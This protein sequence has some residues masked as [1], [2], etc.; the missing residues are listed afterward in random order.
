M[1]TPTSMSQGGSHNSVAHGE[2]FNKLPIIIVGAVVA[3]FAFGLYYAA[4]SRIKPTATFD[5][6]T[7]NLETLN[8][9]QNYESIEFMEGQKDG[10]V[11]AIV[12][13][14][15]APLSGDDTRES[16]LADQLASM[17]EKQR[18]AE[19]QRDSE[20]QSQMVK[21]Q[22]DQAQQA[23][24]GDVDVAAFDQAIA[25]G[26]PEKQPFNYADPS[27][28]PNTSSVTG[29]NN[30]PAN[31]RQQPV[32][33]GSSNR[34]SNPDAAALSS[35]DT[36]GVV[37]GR[38]FVSGYYRNDFTLHESTS[39]PTS[40]YQLMTGTLIPGSMISAANSELPGDL[41]AQVRQD[42]YDSVTGRHLLIPKGSKLFGRY[43]S[44]AALGSERL[45][46]VWDRLILP[47][48]ESLTLGSIQGYDER[49]MSGAKDQVITHFWK[50]LFNA[51]LLSVASN[52][53]EALVDESDKSGSII[54]DITAS[55]GTTSSGA[56]DDYLRHRLRIKPT[57]QIRAGYRFN[58]IV[59]RD[60]TFPEPFEFG[61]TR[62]EIR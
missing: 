4:N 58:I 14:D 54:A 8:I 7:G 56:F 3:L 27:R 12:N 44:Y 61:Y 50:T 46:M 18:L 62:L 53:A 29:A 17:I 22:F 41:V 55:F 51:F 26:R 23:L 34:L 24:E 40:K 30:I 48:G 2:R 59:S 5:G 16:D 47:D 52:T 33:D 49:G 32:S 25:T 31:G 60:I 11:N 57:F 15:I 35:T 43:D 19:Y 9:G 45:L 21:R 6:S 13:D 36:S 28:N 1:A 10:L 37:A 20:I 39:I 42:V 38:D